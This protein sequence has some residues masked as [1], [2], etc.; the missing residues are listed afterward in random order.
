[1]N[2]PAGATPY[3]VAGCPIRRSSDHCVVARSPMLIAAAH[4][5]RR[6]PAPR[7]PPHAFCP[8]SPLPCLVN[9]HALISP[10]ADQEQRQDTM[11]ARGVFP[12]TKSHQRRSR[13]VVS[14]VVK[15][16]IPLPQRGSGIRQPH[17]GPAPYYTP[18]SPP[19][20]R[21]H[22]AWSDAGGSRKAA[23]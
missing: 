1:M 15:V 7:H 3:R 12:H 22:R 9:H 6:H 4:V 8:S 20:T 10:P 5:L 21:L 14:R 23:V 18:R 13:R 19:S 2:S 11:V 17:H 16:Q